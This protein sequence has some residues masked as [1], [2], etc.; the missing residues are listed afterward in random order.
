MP[1]AAPK[2][3]FPSLPSLRQ[4]KSSSHIYSVLKPT[5]DFRAYDT[6]V[7]SFDSRRYLETSLAYDTILILHRP[8][9]V[10]WIHRNE[11][12]LNRCMCMSITNDGTRESR[13]RTRGGKVGTRCRPTPSARPRSHTPIRSGHPLSFDVSLISSLRYTFALPVTV[14]KCIERF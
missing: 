7:K 2:V 9:S 11:S 6:P 5:I 3:V 14:Y 4:T 12:G 8:A 10:V 13:T 1:N